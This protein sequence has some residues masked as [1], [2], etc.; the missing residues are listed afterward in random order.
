[1]NKQLTRQILPDYIDFES[2]SLSNIIE[3]LVKLRKKYPNKKIFIE[4]Y[5]DSYE[6]CDCYRAYFKRLE[7]DE[8]QAKRLTQEKH[9]KEIQNKYAREQYERLKKQFEN[10]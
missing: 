9:T 2:N 6:G 7:T 1:M 3:G 8:E 10:D 4:K 5:Q